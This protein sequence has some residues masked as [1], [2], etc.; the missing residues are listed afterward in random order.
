MTVTSTD[1]NFGRLNTTNFDVLNL[2]GAEDA[3][4]T[5]FDFISG[6]AIRSFVAAGGGFSGSKPAPA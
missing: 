5:I 4:D 2:P 3:D 6:G 1:L